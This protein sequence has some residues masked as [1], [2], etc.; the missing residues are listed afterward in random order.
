MKKFLSLVLAAVMTMSLVTIGAGATE[1][2]DLTDKSE[3]QYSEAVAVMNKI[4]IITGYEDGSFKPTGNLTRGAASKI[5]AYLILGSDAADQLS[6]STAPYKDVKA[7][8]TFAPYIA[9]CKNAN[10]IDGYSDNTFRASNPLTGYAF[11]KMLLTALGYDSK[12]EQFTGAGWETRVAKIAVTNG[13]YNGNSS[14]AGNKPVT[15][16]EACLYAL[17]TLKA[18]IVTYPKNTI[19]VSTGDTNV[20]VNQ[21]DAEYVVNNSGTDG[22]IPVSTTNPLTGATV[23]KDGLMQ[24]A[25]KYWPQLKLSN[26]RSANDNYERPANEWTYKG[27]VIGQYAVAPTFTFTARASGDGLAAKVKSMGLSSYTGVESSAV[28]F[29]GTNLTINGDVQGNLNAYT[30]LG[31]PSNNLQKIADLTGNGTVVEVYT[32]PTAANV[33]TDVVVIRSQ[34][35]QVTNVNTGS[36]AVTVKTLADKASYLVDE[37]ADAYA[38]LS[39]LKKDDYVMV[40]LCEDDKNNMQVDMAY[41]PTVAKGLLSKVS[42]DGGVNYAVTVGGTEYKLA[43]TAVDLDNTKVNSLSLNTKAEPTLFVDK[44]GYATYIKDVVAATNYMYVTKVAFGN[45]DNQLVNMVTGIN[46]KGDTITLNVG[47]QTVNR[48]KL[49]SYKAPT[50]A[51]SVQFGGDYYVTE[52]SEGIAEG[53][54]INTTTGITPGTTKLGSNYFASDVKFIYYDVDTGSVTVKEGVQKVSASN[55]ANAVIGKDNVIVAVYMTSAPEDESVNVLYID[56]IDNS[57]S[58]DNKTAFEYTAYINGIKTTGVVSKSAQAEAKKFYTYSVDEATG[59]YT[60]TPYNRADRTTSVRKDAVLAS[61]P[62][63]GLISL[64]DANSSSA[65]PNFT[66][67]EMRVSGAQV[68]DLRDNPATKIISV[69]ALQELVKSRNVTV[70]I[71]FNG[72][73]DVSGYKSVSYIFIQD[74]AAV[75]GVISSAI[76][77]TSD[78]QFSLSKDTG[79]SA[80]LL[81]VAANTKVYV[82]CDT[83]WDS[84]TANTAGL[85]LTEETKPS[86]TT[87]G[88][89][90]FVMP[91]TDIGASA[92]TVESTDVTYTSIDAAQGT[93]TSVSGN[94]TTGFTFVEATPT[95][96]AGTITLT[97]L[98]SGATVATT[99]SKTGVATVNATGNPIT[100]TGATNT[101]GSTTELTITITA[102]DGV[103]KDTVKVN[104]TLATS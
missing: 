28:P 65:N 48:N 30:Y 45:V 16:E 59:L 95:G 67:Y 9:Y 1:Y 55:A 33:I 24:F 18:T 47:S 35:A 82:K 36:K 87:G 89:Y 40:T 14:L 60:L 43:A 77:A 99:S 46:T 73:K 98:D 7:T 85:K 19:E 90:S 81:S 83:D 84:I 93:F 52:L 71:I 42:V 49:V 96:K 15:R 91:K 63:A 23:Y 66:Y 88:V 38:F 17:N 2:K 103:T 56:S 12:Q 20:V 21:G 3:I 76:A 80:N 50:A 58:V 37:D 51:Q 75:G 34:I 62:S 29:D 94:A 11:S 6:T 100:V 5:I 61:V 86:A 41:A 39:G 92:F 74:A 104:V 13:M 25:E 57:H 53:T 8:D 72:N 31:A 27:I 22:N 26:D 4:G 10:I 101:T 54:Y 44:Y 64:S 32:A 69:E 70:D 97:G 78:L 102:E 79:Y 68:F